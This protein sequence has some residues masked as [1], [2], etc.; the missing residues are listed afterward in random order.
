MPRVSAGLPPRESNGSWTWGT[1]R[2]GN[3]GGE[4]PSPA[5]NWDRHPGGTGRAREQPAVDC[6]GDEPAAGA[7]GKAFFRLGAVCARQF[8]PTISLNPELIYPRAGP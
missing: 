1:S 8:S 2:V 5:G 7:R 3:G 6:H 4:S